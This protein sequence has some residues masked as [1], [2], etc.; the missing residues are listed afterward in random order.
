MK[1]KW[2]KILSW[3]ALL[4]G[5]LLGAIIHIGT[6]L[7][8]PYTSNAS[9]FM[10][11]APQLPTNKLVIVPPAS[12]KRQLLPFMMPNVRY[13]LCRFNIHRSP[14]RIRAQL[15]DPSWTLALYSKAGDNFYIAMGLSSRRLD[16]SIDLVRPA[17]KFLGLFS[18]S[19]SLAADQTK[20]P[21]PHETGLLVI[22]AP[23]N[24][25]AFADEVDR[26][27]KQASCRPIEE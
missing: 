10:K 8:I 23:I 2:L 16:I 22:R 1:L 4:A 26:A 11:L 20:V 5:V 9:A 17:A 18:T 15:L 13:A 7:A 25:T 12:P 6:T 19:N 27:L 14:V 24:G 21:V 3:R